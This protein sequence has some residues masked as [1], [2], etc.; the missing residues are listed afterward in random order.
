MKMAFKHIAAISL[1]YDENTCDWQ[2]T[3]Y[4]TA[5]IFQIWLKKMCSNSIFL[6]LMEIYDKDTALQTSAM[7]GTGEQVDSQR[8]F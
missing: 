5:L 7:F 4:Q 6:G 1:D 3:C 2:S 8:V